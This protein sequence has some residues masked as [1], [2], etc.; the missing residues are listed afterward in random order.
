MAL[1]AQIATTDQP[2]ALTS[3]A[4]TA[5]AKHV[6]AIASV[7]QKASAGGRAISH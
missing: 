1:K 3:P 7:T 4:N 6:A 5:C 2:S